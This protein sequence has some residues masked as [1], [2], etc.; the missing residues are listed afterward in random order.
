MTGKPDSEITAH[1]NTVCKKRVLT[2]RWTQ[3][4]A[5]KIKKYNTDKL[6]IYA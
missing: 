6:Q 1:D 4:N 3:S 2:H 5:K